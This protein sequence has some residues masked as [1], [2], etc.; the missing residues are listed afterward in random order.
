MLA[1]SIPGEY[2][3]V[4]QSVIGGVAVPECTGVMRVWRVTPD[5]ADELSAVRGGSRTVLAEVSWPADFPYQ[6]R[7]DLGNVRTYSLELFD[8]E[9]E[10]LP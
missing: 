5:F 1:T 10:V 7:V 8:A 4:Q 6:R 9:A 2:L 3:V